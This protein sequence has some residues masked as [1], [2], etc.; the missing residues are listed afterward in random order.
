MQITNTLQ[1]TRKKVIEKGGEE[2]HKD[3]LAS[4]AVLGVSRN[5]HEWLAYVDYVNNI[6]VE[7]LVAV[8]VRSAEY[9]RNQIDK[10]EV[11]EKE[12]SPLLEV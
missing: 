5:K 1:T 12:L 6:I 10:D 9:L 8:A 4:N 2:L 11:E 3:I 7:G